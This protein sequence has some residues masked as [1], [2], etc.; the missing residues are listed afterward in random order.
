MPPGSAPR[1]VSGSRGRRCR[2][3]VAVPGQPSRR[4]S[5]P[6]SSVCSGAAGASR[7]LP[8]GPCSRGSWPPRPRTGAET[9]GSP[10]SSARFPAWPGR[11]ARTRAAARSATAA[12]SPANLA[13][14][15]ASKLPERCSRAGRAR[16]FAREASLLT[17]GGALDLARARC[18]RRSGLASPARAP[19]RGDRRRPRG[20][21]RGRTRNL[22]CGL[23]ARLRNG[24]ARP[25]G[26]G[27]NRRVLSVAGGAALSRRVAPRHLRSLRGAARVAAVLRG[28]RGD[29]ARGTGP[30]P[31]HGRRARG[32]ARVGAVRGRPDGRRAT[33]RAAARGSGR[34]SGT[35][36]ERAERRPAALRVRPA[37][38]QRGARRRAARSGS[39]ARD[40]ASREERRAAPRRGGAVVARS[41]SA[42]SRCC[43]RGAPTR[44]LP[45]MGRGRARPGAPDRMAAVGR[46]R[47]G[48]ARSG[49]G[50]AGEPAAREPRAMVRPV[51]PPRGCVPGA[52]AALARSPG[53][54]ARRGR[55]A[56]GGRGSPARTAGGLARCVACRAQP[57]SPA[58]HRDPGEARPPSRGG[59]AGVRL[60]ESASGSR[61]GHDGAGAACRSRS[62]GSGGAA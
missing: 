24:R 30:R 50:V 44:G 5:R 42:C 18:E 45:A 11:R 6:S 26:T 8:R 36:E 53:G 15:P 21:D 47:G 51:G 25:R 7:I 55:R 59:T 32:F 58:A 9:S 35:P 23:A 57:G 2:S 40:R 46:R 13:C 39:A 49:R 19:C 33:S 14:A 38:L 22:G 62:A 16:I 1:A 17:P 34:S 28:V 37:R 48:S 12:T 41:G 3:G 4:C 27:R 31:P 60:E 20:V 52:A 10:A 54:R 61:R 29:R 56:T 43:F